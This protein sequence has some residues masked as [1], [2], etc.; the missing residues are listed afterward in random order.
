M[1]SIQ[2]PPVVVGTVNKLLNNPLQKS[3][4]VFCSLFVFI[5]LMLPLS[6]CRNDNRPSSSYSLC[7]IMPMDLCMLQMCIRTIYG[8]VYMY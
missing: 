5:N 4:L 8:Y 2:T 6:P 1:D 7:M 3:F